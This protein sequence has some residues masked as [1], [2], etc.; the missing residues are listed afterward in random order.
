[1]RS[2]RLLR[3]LL[4]IVG[5]YF[6]FSTTVFSATQAQALPR[7]ASNES[8][9]IQPGEVPAGLSSSDWAGI[10][11]QLAASKYKP[12]PDKNGSGFGSSNPAHG[13]NIHFSADGTT[14]LKPRDSQAQGY[15]LGL[16]LS[17]IG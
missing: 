16:K 12:K 14:T 4:G 15:H 10:Q 17:A 13:W 1:M 2:V 7:Q 3:V 9:L 8:Q 6:V 5:L 11:A